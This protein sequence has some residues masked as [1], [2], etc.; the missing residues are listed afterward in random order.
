MTRI[1]VSLCLLIFLQA[2]EKTI[3]FKL[4][5]TSAKLVVEATIENGRPPLVILSH[6]LNYFSEINPVILANSFVR[7]AEIIISDGT[8]SQKLKEYS[9]PLLPGVSFY[10]YTI[11]SSNLAGSFKG[12]LASSYNMQIRTGS[13]VYEAT[14]TIPALTK[15][16]DSL[17]WKRSPGNPDSTLVTLMGRLYDPPGHGNYIRYFTKRGE[18]PFYPGLNSVY[19]DQ[20]IDGIS[21]DAEVERGV[22]RNAKIDIDNYSFFRRGDTVTVKLCNID[23]A[24]FDFWRTMEYSY[25]SIGNPF[26]AP[27]KVL[28]NIGGSALG[29]FG[30]YAVQ[31]RTLIIPK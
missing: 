21:Y 5:D 11:D 24:C 14:T 1:I 26:A 16:L 9:M 29:Y 20:I 3:T 10:Y 17:W 4:E 18:E 2:C 8:R 6:S 22:D 27:T 28:G 15:T 19:D 13:A 30:G 25:S 7:D 12:A 23:K 31:Y